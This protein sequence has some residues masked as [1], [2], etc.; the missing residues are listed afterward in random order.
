MVQWSDKLII[1][2]QERIAYRCLVELYYVAYRL[3]VQQQFKEVVEECWNNETI[4]HEE[5]IFKNL[6]T[7]LINNVIWI[8]YS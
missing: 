7:L 2:E 5:M 8:V 3:N 6:F 1:R 4:L